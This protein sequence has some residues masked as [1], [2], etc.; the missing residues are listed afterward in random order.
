MADTPG[1]ITVRYGSFVEDNWLCWEPCDNYID[2]IHDDH[3]TKDIHVY[4]ERPN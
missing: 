4:T 1:W 2:C 3:L